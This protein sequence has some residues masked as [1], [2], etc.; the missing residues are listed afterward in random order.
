MSTEKKH[1]ELVQCFGRKKNSV[2]VA[3]IRRGKGLL[4]VNGSPVEL[5]QP[6]LLRI[7]ILEPVF[8]L[9]QKRFSKL[10]VRIR[11]RGGGYT[12][13]I[14]AIRQALSKGVVAWYQKFEN[15]QEKREIKELLLQ[16]DRTL[17]VADPRRCEPKTF[18]GDGARAKR[19]KSYRG[20][21]GR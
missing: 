20:G 4:H 17:L 12:S 7:K 18:G 8:L 5:V 3:S 19:Q 9:G 13:Q 6:E 15:E 21:A 2:A 14:Y 1:L 16:Y 11:S 10:D